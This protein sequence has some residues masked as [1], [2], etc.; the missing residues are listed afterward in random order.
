MDIEVWGMPMRLEPLG[1]VTEKRLLLSPDRFERRELEW[2]ADRLGEGDVFIDVGA[3]IGAFSIWV[4]RLTGPSG[5]ILAIE[6]QPDVCARLRANLSQSP[7]AGA[8]IVEQCA[9]SAMRGTARLNLS[10][11]N[12]GEASLQRSNSTAGCIEVDVW[13]LHLLLTHHGITAIQALKID[14]EGHESE[15]LMPFYQTAPRSLWP[16]HL[17]FERDTG[18]TT[19]SLLAAL[20]GFG[21]RLDMTTKRNHALTLV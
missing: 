5:T 11:C 12:Q 9:I 2:L 13:P 14:V 4:S 1:N 18:A 6:P 19:G 17:I 3:N 16:R 7:A 15:A 8:A 20:S 21:Y 10:D